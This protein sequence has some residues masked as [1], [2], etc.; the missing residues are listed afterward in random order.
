MFLNSTGIFSCRCQTRLSPHQYNLT[1][2]SNIITLWLFWSVSGSSQVKC[3]V[4]KNKGD[5]ATK[6]WKSLTIGLCPVFWYT[7]FLAANMSATD[8]QTAHIALYYASCGKKEQYFTDIAIQAYHMK[9]WQTI[10]YTHTIKYCK[11][12]PHKIYCMNDFL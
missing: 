2:A 8:R 4:F 1:S 7:L 10:I 6:R 12:L 11:R 3:F 5:G 9:Y